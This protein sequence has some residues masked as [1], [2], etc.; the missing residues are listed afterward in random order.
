MGVVTKDEYEKNDRKLL[1]FG[2]TFGHAIELKK[3]ITHGQAISVGMIMAAHLSIYFKLL[4]ID[5]VEAIIS[6]LE[7]YQL[8]TKMDLSNETLIE[9]IAQDKK[10]TGDAISFVLLDGI[11]KALLKEIPLDVLLKATN[12]IAL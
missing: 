3:N 5:Q 4:K 1:N 7:R 12:A 10:I 9:K 2:H 11:G 8:P 6:L